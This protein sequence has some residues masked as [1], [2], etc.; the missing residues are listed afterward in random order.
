MVAV[1]RL[2]HFY[3]Q[4]SLGGL[5]K[6]SSTGEQ[7]FYYQNRTLGNDFQLDVRDPFSILLYYPDYTTL[8]YLDRT[9]N[10]L[11]QYNLASQG[12]LGVSHVA[13]AQ[14][15]QVWL[16][17]PQDFSLKKIDRYGRVLQK[18]QD[19]SLQIGSNLDIEKILVFNTQVL[20]RIPT[21]LLRFNLFGQFQKEIILPS[22]QLLQIKERSA[23]LRVGNM[24]EEY[25]F[26]PGNRQSI[27]KI[28]PKAENV[29]L[30]NQ[31]LYVSRQGQIWVYRWE[32]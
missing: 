11:A 15:N 20:L 30:Q 32:E 4:D 14:D 17:D 9:L 8:I 31:Y 29:F 13:T 12:F 3:A 21:G 1:D 22:G 27:F 10:E 6:Y 23:W 26:F 16:Y 2:G 28:N 25:F 19:L 7:L 18:S 5:Y 24:I